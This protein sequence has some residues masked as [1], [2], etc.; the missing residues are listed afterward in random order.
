MKRLIPTLL[1]GALAAAFGAQAATPQDTL[2]VV[3]SLEGIISLDPAESFETVSSAN[4]VNLYQRLVAPDRGA[5]QTLAPDAAASWQAGA[6][7]HSL[8]FTLKPQQRFAS[9]NPL[10]PEDVIFSLVRAVKLNKAPSF[11]LGEFGWTPDNVEQHLKKV[12]DNQ[13]Q[14]SWPANIG[15]ELALRLLTA[16]VG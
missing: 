1:Y 9:G 2:V 7:G 10:R 14:L 13:V 16:N 15:S 5:P 11:I 4:L 6:D 12:G 3:S 8:I